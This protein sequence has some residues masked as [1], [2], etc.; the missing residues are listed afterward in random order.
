MTGIDSLDNTSHT[1]VLFSMAIRLQY[2]AEIRLR[3]LEPAL[4]DCLAQVSVHPARVLR[5]QRMILRV[6]EGG[7]RAAEV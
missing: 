7:R 5:L 6:T 4:Q 3:G 2:H 1:P